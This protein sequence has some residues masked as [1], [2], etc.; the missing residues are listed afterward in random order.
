MS[1]R[2]NR[3]NHAAA[4]LGLNPY[5]W[6]NSGAR[7]RP[8]EVRTPVGQTNKISHPHYKGETGGMQDEKT[9]ETQN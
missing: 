5:G 9:A 4:A 6:G 3:T 8:R 1:K 7:K 2:K